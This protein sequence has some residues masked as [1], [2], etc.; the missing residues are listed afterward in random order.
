MSTNSQVNETSVS[1]RKIAVRFS[2]KQLFVA[3][4]LVAVALVCL[5]NARPLL[6][7]TVATTVIAIL[8]GSVLVAIQTRDERRAYWVGVAI[9]GW[10]YFCLLAFFGRDVRDPFG[11]AF[12][13]FLP[14]RIADFA[15]E[16]MYYPATPTVRAPPTDDPFGDPQQPSLPVQSLPGPRIMTV[17]FQNRPARDDFSVLAHSFFTLLFAHCGGVFS[18]FLRRRR[19]T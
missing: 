17:Q 3:V 6:A 10:A 11:S 1:S 13:Y 18:V 4:T 16:K 2:I 7:A 8:V 14:D 19:P 15:Y 5:L 9:C 12:H